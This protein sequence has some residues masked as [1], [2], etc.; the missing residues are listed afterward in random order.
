MDQHY[1]DF[2]FLRV[3]AQVKQVLSDGAER[4]RGGLLSEDVRAD[5]SPEEAALRGIAAQLKGVGLVEGSMRVLHFASNL[6]PW[7]SRGGDRVEGIQQ[8]AAWWIAEQMPR[9]FRAFARANASSYS[10]C[11]KN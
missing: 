1:T 10:A 2:Q 7:V 4:L 6:K 8:A 11:G 5:E 3:S 9:S